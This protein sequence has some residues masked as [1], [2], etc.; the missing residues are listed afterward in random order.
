M[1]IKLAGNPLDITE[2]LVALG[3]RQTPRFVA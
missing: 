3:G 1:S 2:A